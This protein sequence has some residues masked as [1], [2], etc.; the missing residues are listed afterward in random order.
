M[1]KNLNLSQF[2]ITN[3]LEWKADILIRI[4][5]GFEIIIFAITIYTVKGRILCGCGNLR[6]SL[7]LCNIS[8]AN[9]KT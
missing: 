8:F 6:I 1:L 5:T 2:S 4:G 7:F 9:F 3:A